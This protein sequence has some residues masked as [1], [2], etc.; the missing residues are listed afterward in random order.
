MEAV[1]NNHHVILLLGKICGIKLHE[2]ISGKVGRIAY[3][4]WNKAIQD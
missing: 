3:Q 4:K 1:L 2:Y